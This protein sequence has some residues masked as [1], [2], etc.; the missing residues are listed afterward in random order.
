MEGRV[1]DMAAT[2]QVA[3]DALVAALRPQ[4]IVWFGSAA[5]GRAGPNSDL[6]FLIVAD[7]QA[8]SRD[9]LFMDATRA[10]W[11]VPAPIDL[12]IYYADEVADF[13]HRMGNVVQQAVQHGRVVHGQL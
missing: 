3:I 9:D 7:R 6:D 12:L 5:A 13:R 4:A 8:G 2:A 11:N 10:V 1:A